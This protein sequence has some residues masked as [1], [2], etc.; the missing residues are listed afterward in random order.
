MLAEQNENITDVYP[1]LSLVMYTRQ[2]QCLQKYKLIYLCRDNF[3]HF[4]RT[5]VD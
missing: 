5:L 3:L 4:T 1:N 2:G